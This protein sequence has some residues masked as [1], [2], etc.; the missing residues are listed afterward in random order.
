MTDLLAGRY[1]LVARISRGGMGAVWK[2]Y[3]HR[4]RRDVA[5]KLLHTW[6]AEDSELRQRFAR[7]A[8]V[9]APLENEHIVRLYDYGDDGETPFLVME[10]VDGASL[11][12][13]A[14]GRVFG[15][16]QAREIAVPIVLALSYA[17]ARGIVH[18]DLTPGNVLIE[19]RTGRVVVSDFGLARIARSSTSV[20]AQG[21]LLGTPEYWSPEQARGRDSDSA[22]DMYALGCLLFWLL[23][24]RT[25]FEGDDRLAVG[26]RRAHEAAPLLAT[27]T[28]APPEAAT[29]LVDGLLA[30]EPDDRPTALEAL[31]LLGVAVPEIAETV[32]ATVEA[33]ERHTE[34]FGPSL[35]TEVRA[36]PVR[37]V[38]RRR[39]RGRRMVAVAVGIVAAAA[40][41]F[42]G[43]TI[44]N[45]DRVV[46]VPAVTGLTV[47]Q[48]RA[49]LGQAAHV[50]AADAPLSVGAAMYS[51]SVAPGHVISQTPP[52][53]TR[54]ERASLDVVVRVS[55]G[56]A[57]AVVPDVGSALIGDARDTLR[58]TGFAVRVEEEESW[59]VPEGRVISSDV[60]AGD[61]VRRPGP[62]TLRVSSG[63]PRAP[64]P[65]VRG[66]GVDEATARLDGSFQADVVE[67]GS[68]TAA[69]G[70]I[71]RQS[72]EPG[73]RAVLGS[74]VVLTVARAPEWR[75]TWSDSGNG[76]YDSGDIRV[77]AAEGKWRIVVELRPRYLIF[78]SG[79]AAFSWDGAGAGQIGLGSVGSDEVSPLSGAGTYRIH[80]RPHGSVTWSVRVEQFG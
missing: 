71:L 35:E 60:A 66:L 68:E 10:L 54:V 24:G 37:H 26:L 36:A 20:T 79:S 39:R 80:V 22:T 67:E 42:V 38:A 31:G 72:P 41:A 64:V 61:Q 76:S 19:R 9:L 8:R 50:G 51:E 77:D 16:E 43:A 40:L 6:I 30:S 69:V 13:V 34:V 12:E 11:A 55:R 58:R 2:A 29:R 49:A 7:E 59:D 45:A 3:D 27:C 17:H 48:A 44:A 14:R 65:D 28:I 73:A 74:K 15:W 75:A 47:P 5:V 52:A 78:G 1:E 23:T 46:E 62:I 70:S 18:R 33:T 56:T 4:L 63:P 32:T 53:A 57:F 25:P 21:T